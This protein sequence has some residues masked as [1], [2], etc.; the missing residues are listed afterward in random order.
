MKDYNWGTA[1]LVKW[2]A[3]DGKESEGVLYVPEN[4]DQSPDSQRIPPN[5]EVMFATG[6]PDP[7]HANMSVRVTR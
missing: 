5:A 3:Y 6:A 2:R 1:Q 4:L 7:A